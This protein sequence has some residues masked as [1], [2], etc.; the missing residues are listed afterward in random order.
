MNVCECGHEEL[1]SGRLSRPE[2]ERRVGFTTVGT[3]LFQ[4]GYPPV[5]DFGFDFT[6]ISLNFS[7]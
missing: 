5:S 2:V 1:Q 6:S 4:S 3:T 7:N